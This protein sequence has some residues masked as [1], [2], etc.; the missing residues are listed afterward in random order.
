MLALAFPRVAA[1]HRLDEYLQATR[2]SIESDQVGLE[3]DL[4]PG[5]DVAPMMFALINTDRDGRISAREGRAYANQVLKDLSLELDGRHQQL[6]LVGSHFPSF[7]EMIAGIG[8]IRIEAR[9]LVSSA[10]QGRYLLFYQNNH[11]PD[12]SVYL[13]NA[14]VP[15]SRA[16]EITE[17]NRDTRQ[18]GLRLGFNV[19][20]NAGSSR[21]SR[22]LLIAGLGFSTLAGYSYHRYTAHRRFTNRVA[23]RRSDRRADS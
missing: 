22:L 7:Q 14:L 20:S 4:T 6:A 5:V 2:I 15:A 12:G 19:K 21:V 10:E 11:R 1:A 17:Q 18:R 13:V 9:S 16:I 8:T 23:V 3:I